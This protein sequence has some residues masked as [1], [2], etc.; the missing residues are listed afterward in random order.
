MSTEVLVSQEELDIFASLY[1]G[2]EAKVNSDNFDNLT[3]AE[4][5]ELYDEAKGIQKQYRNLE[6]TVKKDGNSIYGSMASI[7]FSLND[8]EC[9]SDITNTGKHFTVLVDHKINGFLQTWNTEENLKIIQE[10]YP[11]VYSLRNFEE[12][13]PDTIDDVCI[14]GDTDSRYVDLHMI[15]GMLL[16]EDGKSLRYPDI[17]VEEG[18]DEL[19]NFSV[20]FVQQFVNKII[21]NALDYDIDFRQARPGY[22]KMAHEITG[23]KSIFRAKKNYIIPICWKDGRR[24]PEIKLKTV[25][26]EMQKGGMNPRIKKILKKLVNDYIILNKSEEYLRQECIKLIRYIKNRGERKMIYR[27][28]SVNDLHKIVFNDKTGE[29]ETDASHQGMKIALFWYNFIHKNNLTDLYKPPFNGQKMYHY[30]DVNGNIVGVPDDIDIDSIKGLPQPDYTK[31]LKD[32]LVKNLLKY[33]S[34]KRVQDIKPK[35]VDN[36]LVG[37]QKII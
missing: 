16:T 14:Y 2:L 5:E 34:D 3:L 15:Y 36:F 33:I 24:L 10:F 6:L 17:T 13:K 11:Q 29:Y 32:I 9:A 19:S 27:I 7:Y 35:D 1:N 20:H 23:T 8:F 12:Y 21:K 30:Y 28:N 37:V 4:L 25:G 26:V 18:L 31:M 22:M